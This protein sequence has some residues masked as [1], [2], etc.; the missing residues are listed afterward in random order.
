MRTTIL[1]NSLIL[2]L[3]TFVLGS[4]ITTTQTPISSPEPLDTVVAQT[5]DLHET[6]VAG[7]TAISRLTQ[8]AGPT[9]TLPPLNLA[10]TPALP[11]VI[12]STP[13]L[14]AFSTGTPAPLPRARS[15]I[16]CD[17]AELVSDISVQDETSFWPGATFIKTWRIRNIGTCTWPPGYSMVFTGGDAMGTATAVSLP[18][19]VSPGQTVDISI[20]LVA[21]SQPGNYTSYWLLR[22]LN[23]DT[24]GAAPNGNGPFWAQIRVN[25][26]AQTSNY[27]FDFALNYCSAIWNSSNGNLPCPTQINTGSGSVLLLDLPILETGRREYQS[28]LETLP[29]PVLNGWISGTYPQYKVYSGDHFITDV[30]CLENSQGCDVVFYVDFQLPDGTVNH[31]GNWREVF[32]RKITHV[33]LDLTFLTDQTVKFILG[34]VNYSNPGLPDAFWLAPSI[35]SESTSIGNQAAQAAR[36]RV[37]RDM[38]LDANTISIVRVQATQWSDSCLEVLVPNQV[39]ASGVYPGYR[40]ILD[41][42]G[43]QFEAHTNQDG[44]TIIWF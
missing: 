12:S 25:Q 7:Q 44:S 8:I 14:P 24:F 33:D 22:N 39:C 20:P 13:T 42:N 1:R 9:S 11:I 32:D 15:L 5:V 23:G 34:V 19:L 40:V 2:L 6:L 27:A 35:R 17:L 21:P 31:M 26:P 38:G 16:P 3:I 37:A 4:C 29:P 41:W 18:G 28:V 10:N 36:R 30:G 43:Q